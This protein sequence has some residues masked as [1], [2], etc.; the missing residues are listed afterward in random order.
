MISL[1]DAPIKRKLMLVILLTTSFA[2][3]LM[4]GAVVTYELITFRAALTTNTGV[5][6]K[7]VG[8]ISTS[9]L[10]FDNAADATEVLNEL[11]AEPQINA[12]AI[13]NAKGQIFATFVKPDSKGEIPVSPGPD[14]SAFTASHLIIFMPIL[15]DDRRLGTIYLQ[16]DLRQMYSRLYAYGG[17]VLLAGIGAVGGAVLVSTKLQRRI[18][19]PVVQLAAT[20]RAVSE[21]QDYNVR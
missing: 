6:A 8:S 3:L 14:G 9:S 10:A 21:R 15:Q 19:L 7:M 16:A 5:L 1:R 2:L 11:S 18:S 17:L 12:A 13:Y 4:A 20:A